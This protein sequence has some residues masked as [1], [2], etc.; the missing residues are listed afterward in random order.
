MRK[1]M[2]PI[3]S[4]KRDGIS[5][6]RVNLLVGELDQNAPISQEVAKSIQSPPMIA[7]GAIAGSPSILI[8]QFKRLTVR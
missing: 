5:A 1:I 7:P 4:M 2:P 8:M 3:T 6:P